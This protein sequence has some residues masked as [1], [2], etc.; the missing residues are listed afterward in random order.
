MSLFVASAVSAEVQVSL[1]VASAV[2][3]EVQ[4]SL[5]TCIYLVKLKGHFSWQAQHSVKFG[6]VAGAHARCGREK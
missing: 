2:F 5:G 1:F 4:V 6:K 3:A